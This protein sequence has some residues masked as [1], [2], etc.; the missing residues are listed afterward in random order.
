MYLDF[1]ENRPGATLA[2]PYSVRPKPG[3]T[4]S[5]PLKWEE[6]KPWLRMSD[7]TIFNGMD[8]LQNERDLFAPVLAKELICI[9]LLAMT[10]CYL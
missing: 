8:R 6:V 1:L 10:R 3:A 9:K 7:F 2:A 5:M 4:V